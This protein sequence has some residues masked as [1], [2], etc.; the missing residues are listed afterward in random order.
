[1]GGGMGLTAGASHRIIAQASKVAMPEIHIGLFPDVG[2]GFFLNRLPPGVGVVMALTG[3]VINESDAIH[4]GLF[5]AFMP[6]ESWTNAI[7]HLTQLPFSGDWRQHQA[8]VSDWM[9]QHDVSLD[10]AMASSMLSHYAKVIRWIG[11]QATPA[12]ILEQLQRAAQDDPWFDAPASSLARGSPIAAMVSHRYLRQ[13][14]RGSL[15]DVL[16]LDLRLA[17]RFLRAQDFPEGV[18]ALLIDKDRKPNWQH[19]DFA[20]VKTEDVDAYF[21]DLG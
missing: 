11:T 12:G 13:S 9:R 21:L 17:R 15:D 14:Y 18:R 2:G 4:V 8:L 5:D 6:Q 16:S 10:E 19:S 1:M 7:D 3:L 20:D